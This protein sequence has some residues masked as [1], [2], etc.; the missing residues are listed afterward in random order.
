MTDD[1][2]V[3][4]LEEPL[5]GWLQMPD[6]AGQLRGRVLAVEVRSRDTVWIKFEAPTWQRWST[7][8]K[9]GEPS[10]EGVGPGVMT[11]WAPAPCVSADDE[12]HQALMQLVQDRAQHLL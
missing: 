6:T 3:I 4:D 12:D 10:T 8:T 2:I 9:V 7:Q 1:P 5:V 11:I